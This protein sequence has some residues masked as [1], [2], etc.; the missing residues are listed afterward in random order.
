MPKLI[1]KIRLEEPNRI[2]EETYS[3]GEFGENDETLEDFTARVED[4]LKDI[5]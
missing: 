5:M 3:L 1:V 4:A 2:V